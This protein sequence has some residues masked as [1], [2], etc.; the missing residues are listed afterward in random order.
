M[1][2]LR[3]LERLIAIAEAVLL[4]SFPFCCCPAP[5]LELT[6]AADIYLFLLKNRENDKQATGRLE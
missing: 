6:V 5:A 2:S 3:V 1:R 4:K